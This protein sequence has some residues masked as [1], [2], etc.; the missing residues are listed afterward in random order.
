[1]NNI[2]W[3]AKD[4]LKRNFLEVPIDGDELY[5]ERNE[6]WFSTSI[7]PRSINKLIKFIYD[8]IHD[9]KLSAY[10]ENEEMFEIIIHIDSYGGCITSIFKFIDFVEQLKKKKIRFRTIINGRACSA[11][12][13]MA[14][15]G[16]KKHITKHSY[17]MIH[18]LQCVAGGYH[19]HIQSYLKYI[20]SLHSDIVEL[21][22]KF[23]SKTSTEAQPIT[24]QPITT[25]PITTQ[26]IT[27]QD[28][29]AWMIKETW[30]NAKEYLEL[31]FV[32]EII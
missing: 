21:Y 20:S 14:I 9:E 28:I 6:I 32:D 19:T 24:T 31:G 11:A 29:E 12:T 30:F 8:I 7:S 10:R 23:K 15:V 3:G 27:T 26:P 22:N 17:A 4:G 2:V 25:Q 5:R 16:D 1:M 13:L 18:E